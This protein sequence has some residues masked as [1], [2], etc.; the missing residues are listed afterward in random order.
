MEKID[1]HNGRDQLFL[2]WN[3]IVTASVNVFL[4]VQFIASALG[5]DD[6]KLSRDLHPKYTDNLLF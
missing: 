1:S 5:D 3:S 2:V 6:W 4:L